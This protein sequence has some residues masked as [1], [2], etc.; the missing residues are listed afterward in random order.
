MLYLT[1]AREGEGCFECVPGIFRSLPDYLRAHPGPLVD[2]RG[3]PLPIDVSGH[4]IVRVPLRAGDLIVWNA[5]LPH[6]GGPNHGSRP[7][8][9]M[10]VTMHPEGREQARMERILWW[11]QK[12]APTWWRG[13]EDK[14]TRNPGPQGSSQG[15][16][17]ALWASIG[18]PIEVGATTQMRARGRAP[19]RARCAAPSRDAR[20]G[21]P[22]ALSDGDRDVPLRRDKGWVHDRSRSS[23]SAVRR[24]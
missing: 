15:W 13:G 16:V 1:D 5:H 6:H 8:I 21:R 12:R 22:Q 11:Q 2:A 24:D 20:G 23:C 7:R 3:E 19:A 17:G 14:S 9:S 18:G 4:D 10:A